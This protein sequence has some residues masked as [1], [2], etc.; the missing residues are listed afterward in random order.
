[1][2]FHKKRIGPASPLGKQ[3]KFYVAQCIDKYM[4]CD[5]PEISLRD[6]FFSDAQV[7]DWLKNTYNRSGKL[8][9][10]EKKTTGIGSQWIWD[11]AEFG[12]EHWNTGGSESQVGMHSQ[13]EFKEA[14]SLSQASHQTQC[15]LL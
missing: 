6:F 8:L 11:F 13:Q 4:L 12:M 10:P 3:K 2:V 9:D 14:V 5:D 1:M 15:L 7:T